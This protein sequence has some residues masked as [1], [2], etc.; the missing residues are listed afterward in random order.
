VDSKDF[1]RAMSNKSCLW[2]HLREL[3]WATTDPVDPLSLHTCRRAAEMRMLR[4]YLNEIWFRIESIEDIQ[5]LFYEVSIALETARKL[6]N[7]S[8]PLDQVCRIKYHLFY[9]VYWKMKNVVLLAIEVYTNNPAN[10]E[11][12]ILQE[13]V[14]IVED[15]LQLMENEDTSSENLLRFEWQDKI[16]GIAAAFEHVQNSDTRGALDL[17]EWGLQ[18][19]NQLVL[20]LPDEL[21]QLKS[22][23]ET[24]RTSLFNINYLAGSD[25][26]PKL[27]FN[28]KGHQISKP[29][30]QCLVTRNIKLAC[31]IEA[32]DHKL[33]IGENSANEVA[34]VSW[35]EKTGLLRFRSEQGRHD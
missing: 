12:R 1:D 19:F 31:L 35:E 20:L 30:S 26:I 25:W 8:M 34:L 23:L 32:K 10:T 29:V 6:L 27:L 5:S 22:S 4:Q 7:P 15:I 33:I 11:D 9:G 13:Q 18:I 24:R 2:F 17:R 16:R 28:L 21:M 14:C 3:V